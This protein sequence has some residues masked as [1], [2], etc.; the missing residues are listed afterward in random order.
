MKILLLAPDLNGY[1]K[2]L[3][4]SLEKK[5]Y[6]VTQ[7]SKFGKINKKNISK[8][9][10]LC[11]SFYSDWKVNFFKSKIAEIEKRVYSSQIDLIDSD[12]DI[13]LDLVGQS[14]VLF[15]EILKDKIKN[16]KYI[17]YIW[18]DKKYQKNISLICDFYDE[19]FTYNK[20]DSEEMNWKY[21]PNFYCSEFDK[22]VEKKNKL[23]YVGALRNQ[24]RI[25]IIL[26]I[27]EYLE[28]FGIDSLLFLCERKRVKNY[29]I[30][31]NYV[32]VVHRVREKPFSFEEIVKNT[33]E[34]KYLLD[35]KFLNQTGLGLRPIE[36]IGAGCK[37][38]TTNKKIKYYDFYNE[39]NI[40]I[41]EENLD[42]INKLEEFIQ[43]PFID[44]D[45]KT[46]YKYSI[47]CWIEEI[48][49]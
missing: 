15:L 13:V 49:S 48:L 5:G 29:F 47:E 22:T 2:S 46:L 42:N 33:N 21:R 23:F 17:L 8:L 32:K 25:N 18:D 37:L 1:T 9:D 7:Y 40:F 19:I 11:R 43:K 34:S 30:F 14:K 31:K 16:A 28:K 35:I 6:E 20:E 39:N 3:I 10:R 12:Y 24:V 38:I 36:A 26:R 41:L 4:K 27:D 45:E 44:Y